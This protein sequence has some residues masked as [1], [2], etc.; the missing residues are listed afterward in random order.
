MAPK[1]ARCAKRNSKK[2]TASVACALDE[3]PLIT[4][5]VQSQDDTAKSLGTA[6]TDLDNS[7]KPGDTDLC[8]V[9]VKRKQNNKKTLQKSCYDSAHICPKRAEIST[10]EHWENAFIL[11]FV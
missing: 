9:S 7:E 3:A 11:L 6:E 2:R 10:H 1:K 8:S 4:S 5:D